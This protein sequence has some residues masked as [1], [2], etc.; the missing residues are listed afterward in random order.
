MPKLTEYLQ[1]AAAAEYLG[2]AQ[3]TLRKWAGRG[4]IPM[5][6]NPAN[7]YRLF[8]RA[9][10]RVTTFRT[11]VREFSPPATSIVLDVVGSAAVNSIV[12]SS[13]RVGFAFCHRK[14]L[15]INKSLP[16]KHLRRP[17]KR[18]LIRRGLVSGRAERPNSAARRFGR[19]R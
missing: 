6:R 18:V 16:K 17:K 1:T 14:G 7:G 15:G 2:V 13:K 12:K 3:N 9:L 19:V 5:H 8:K 10:L 11:F 4:D